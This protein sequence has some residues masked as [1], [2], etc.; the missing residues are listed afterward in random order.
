MNNKILNLVEKIERV[1][2]IT[3][4]FS[5]LLVVLY[6]TVV[7]LGMLFSGIALGIQ[8]S[9]TIDNNILTHLH[10]VFGGFLSVLIGIELLH[11]IKMYLKED[12]VHVEIV[13]LV[14]LIGVSR[15]VIDL[16]FT[17]L[18]PLTIFGIS[19]LIIVL[20]GGYFLIKKGMRI[21]KK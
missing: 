14:A 11:T 13:L 8:N 4:L 15:H 5:L 1:I 21:K 12:I 19:S 18:E 2:I 20:S 6:T 10:K 17:H 7:F 9:F 3:L 16:D